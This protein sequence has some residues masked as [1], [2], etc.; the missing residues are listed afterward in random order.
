MYTYYK[1]I[2]LNILIVSTIYIALTSTIGYTNRN[3]Y[4]NPIS[5]INYDRYSYLLLIYNYCILTAST[6]SQQNLLQIHNYQKRSFIHMIVRCRY[7]LLLIH[8]IIYVLVVSTCEVYRYPLLQT[9]LYGNFWFNK[10][11]LCRFVN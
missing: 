1:D 4:N 9:Y 7:C 6:V 2:K 10:R 3:S 5:L 8:K 11:L